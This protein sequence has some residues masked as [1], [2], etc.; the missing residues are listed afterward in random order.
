MAAY[1]SS[2]IM[3]DTDLQWANLENATL[4]YATNLTP[5]QIQSAKIDRETILPHYL[6]VHWISD[7]NFHCKLITDT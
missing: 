3:E 6:E 5:S 4:R 1:L 7:N 2:A